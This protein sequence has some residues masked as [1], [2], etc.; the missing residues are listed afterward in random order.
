MIGI[1]GGTGLESPDF[2]NFQEEIEINTK[3]G[4]PSSNIKIANFADK[5]I[6]FI[7]RHGIK[8][9]ITPS[10]VNNRANI[11]ALKEINCSC[12]IATTACGSLRE[13]INRGDFIIPDQFI[14]FTRLRKLSFFDT[15]ENGKMKHTPM[16]YPYNENLRQQLIESAIKSKHT[17]HTKGT[18]ITIEGPRFS[19]FAESHMF[20]QW[21]AD[22]I[23]M[24]TAPET[25]LANEA[26]IPYAILA[27]ST[28]YDC[29][30]TDEEPVSLEDVVETFRNN[31]P[32][33]IEILSDFIKNYNAPK[34]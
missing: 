17:H 33:I 24:S 31:I 20:R 23:N 25:I 2:L 4:K 13:E 7:S 21:G 11:M 3:Y 27:L 19:S 8:H 6:A 5:K 28:D 26:E 10:G 30:K 1:I 32:K 16:A 15:F 29:W 18:V 14:D 34:K 9:E 12:I 22:I